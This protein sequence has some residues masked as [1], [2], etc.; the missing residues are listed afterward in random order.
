[1]N[2]VVMRKVEL[3]DAD[4]RVDRWFKRHYPDVG[5]GRLEKLLR[6]G[7]VRVNGGRV[8]AS[9]RLLVGDEVRVPPLGEAPKPAP[10]AAAPKPVSARALEI[11]ETLKKAILHRDADVLVINKPAGLAVQGGS[12][13]DDA[14]L[15]A[16]LDALMF[17]AAERPRLVHRLDKDTSGVLVLA[18]S[19]QAATAL[20]KSFKARDAAKTYWALVMGMPK[21]TRGRIDLALAKEGP[22]GH[23]KMRT[24]QREDED[25]ESKRAVTFYAVVEQAAGKVS[26]LAMRPLTGRTHQLRAHAAF[27]GTPIVGDGKYGG[28]E[29][30]LTGGISRKLHLH[31]R[32]IDIAHPAG[33][34]LK[35]EAPLPPHMAESFRLLGFEASQGRDVFAE[36][37]E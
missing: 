2:A 11:G 33:G 36:L 23:E 21:P 22:A 27:L 34:R 35:V 29:A 37:D 5:H 16:A 14:H 1:M 9:D 24:V 3:A 12:G 4:M 17:E 8:K 13:L 20:A 25:D 31:A 28:A 26:W 30:F 10:D 7:Q 15:D 32:A 18:R 19:R 6:T